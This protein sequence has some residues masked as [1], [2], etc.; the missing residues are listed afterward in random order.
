MWTSVYDL[1]GRKKSQTAPDAGGSRYGYDDAGNPTSTTDAKHVEL[2]YTYDLLGRRL[3]GKDTSKDN[4]EFASWTYDTLRIGLPTSSPRVRSR[5]ASTAVTAS[6][7]TGTSS[8]SRARRGKRMS[9]PSVRA[10]AAIGGVAAA[11]ADA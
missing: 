8:G 3:T 4:F 9:M 6:G 2:D 7:P 5:A 1:L 11:F 10:S